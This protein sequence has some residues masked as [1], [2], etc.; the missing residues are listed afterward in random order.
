MAKL[1]KLKVRLI[2]STMPTT[3]LEEG[4]LDVGIQDMAQM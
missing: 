4:A 1:K 3:P 2:C